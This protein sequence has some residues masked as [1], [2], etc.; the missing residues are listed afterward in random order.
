MNNEQNSNNADNKQLNIA[1]VSHS[2]IDELLPLIADNYHA[3]TTVHK[4]YYT[5][6]RWG[7]INGKIFIR[8]QLNPIANCG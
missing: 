7:T 6:T 1:G 4:G 2:C 3:E 8:C 5:N